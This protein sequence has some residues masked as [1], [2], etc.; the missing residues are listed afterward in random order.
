MPNKSALKRSNVTTLPTV[1]RSRVDTSPK[2]EAFR[3]FDTQTQ[4]WKSINWIEAYQQMIQA[5]NTLANENFQVGD[6]ILLTMKNS[7]EWIYVEQAA[8]YL[9]LVV[10]ALPPNLPPGN[11]CQIAEEVDAKIIFIDSDNIWHALQAN[12]YLENNSVTVVCYSQIN[13]IHSAIYFKEW[14]QNKSI[15][16][17]E[18]PTSATNENSLAT[19]I[20]TSGSCGRPKGVKHS[21]KNLIN[22]AY[23][24]LDRIEVNDQDKMLSVT[25][26]SH[27]LERIA[28]YYVPMIAGATIVF[29]KNTDS[30]LGDL[31][32]SKATILVTTPH[33]LDRAYKLLLDHLI[34][35]SNLV[36]QYL[37]YIHGT[38]KWRLKFLFWPI[39]RG[40][41][42]SK[43]KNLLLNQL[44]FVISGGSALSPKIISLSKFLNLPVLQGYG[45]TEAGGVVSTN[46][47]N[48][49]LVFS[50]GK[51][52]NNTQIRLSEDH[53]LLI[54][55]NSLMLGYWNDKKSEI[56]PEDWLKTEDLVRLE[57]DY[58]F[59]EGRKNETIHLSTGEAILPSPIEQQLRQD[60]LFENVMLF[61]DNKESLSLFCQL[62]LD[63]W[64][65]FRKKYAK[66]KELK[67]E[68]FTDRLKSILLIRI[69]A[70]LQTVPGHPHIHLVFPTLDPWN[71]ENGLLNAQ[72]KVNKKA[73]EA[74]FDKDI[75]LIN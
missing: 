10:V 55:N 62:N 13:E 43:A 4:C 39:I 51:A 63:T 48:Q 60:A 75:N 1:F 70:I 58:L 47:I 72:G 64:Q 33:R 74:F 32:E 28:G 18:T 15:G 20:Y 14:L 8:L 65:T 22:N 17:T 19:I 37:N 45:L 7:P 27:C 44:K 3:F 6:R 54:H 68:V 36:D 46:S 73:V 24:C 29:P 38:E 23:A 9:G 49:N 11:I 69:N 2:N 16:K 71:L 26:I 52:L 34:I 56:R 12:T 5:R 66:R 31:A 42:E 25:P 53:E 67:S 30:I 41:I 21:H 40:I 35:S 50:V 61:G 57:N 59:I